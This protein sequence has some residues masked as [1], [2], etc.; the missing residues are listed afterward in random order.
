[1]KSK[2]KIYLVLGLMSTT[3]GMS[4]F[5]SNQLLKYSFLLLGILFTAIALIKFVKENK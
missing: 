1:M 5:N 2:N 3:L 4:I